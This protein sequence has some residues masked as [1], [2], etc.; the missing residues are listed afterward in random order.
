MNNE[1]ADNYNVVMT[2]AYLREGKCSYNEGREDLLYNDVS[3]IDGLNS[4]QLGNT[5]GILIGY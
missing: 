5:G 2:T 3:S 1:N 4:D